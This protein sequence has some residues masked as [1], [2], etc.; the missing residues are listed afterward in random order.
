MVKCP[1]SLPAFAARGYVRRRPQILTGFG[2]TPPPAGFLRAFDETLPARI[3]AG[4]G[5]TPPKP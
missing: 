2:E 1:S 5:Q 3:L 4:F